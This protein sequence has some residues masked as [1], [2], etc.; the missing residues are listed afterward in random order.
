M[1]VYV[2]A[3]KVACGSQKGALAHLELEVQVG[4]CQIWMLEPN[5]ES[6]QE[7]YMFLSTKPSLQPPS[8][9]IL[10]LPFFKKSY[11]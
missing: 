8:S 10:F 9:A 5:S 6:L 3:S 4:D 2:H 11:F 1:K 7:E